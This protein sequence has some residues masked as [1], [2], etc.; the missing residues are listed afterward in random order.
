MYDKSYLVDEENNLTEDEKTNRKKFQKFT[1]INEQF[2]YEIPYS[3]EAYKN[4]KC[5]Q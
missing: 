2:N 1:N 3:I 4:Y 5:I